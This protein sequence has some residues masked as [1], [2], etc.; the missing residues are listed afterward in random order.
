MSAIPVSAAVRNVESPGL[1]DFAQS[2]DQLVERIKARL[3]LPKLTVIEARDSIRDCFVATYMGGIAANVEALNL[4]ATLPEIQRI[5]ETI[6]RTRLV[7]YGASWER[8]SVDALEKV[9]LE[10]DAEL[11]F[12][13]LPAESLAM[14]DRV[15]SLLLAKASGML[16]HRGDKSVVTREARSEDAVLQAMR[17]T[18]SASLTQL[19]QAVDAQ[20]SG[21]ELLK[22]VAKLT[23]LVETLSAL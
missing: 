5:S 23:R 3:A 18:V 11:H 19:Q 12:D 14:H 21:D 8:P 17:A 4:K 13:E 7:K 15:C 22:R 20:E 1:A 10:A 16:P 2:R 6:F 9:K